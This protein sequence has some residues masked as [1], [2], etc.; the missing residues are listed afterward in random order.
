MTLF[1]GLALIA[2]FCAAWAQ[3]ESSAPDL[4]TL[5]NSTEGL[6]EIAKVVAYYPDFVEAVA[7]LTNITFLAPSDEAIIAL[8]NTTRG[9]AY[10]AEG[11]D[12]FL[13]L[14]YYHTLD[15]LYDNIT[16]YTV[17]PTLLTSSDY[18]NVTGGQV[19]GAYYEDDEELIGFY[20]GLDISP[21][22][23]R[24]PIPFSGGIMYV[25]DGVLNIPVSLT[26][27]VVGEYNGTAFVEAL[28]Q[29]GLTEEVNT[30]PDSTYFVPTNDGVE[31]VHHAL[32][33][34]SAEELADVLKYHV[35][36]GTVL[37][38]HDLEGLNG[39]TVTTLQ[40]QSLSIFM[41]PEEE[42]FINGAG[43]TYVDLYLANGVVHLIDNVLN[44]S[45]TV[46]P[47]VNGTEDGVPAFDVAASTGTVAPTTYS[48]LAAAP[49]RTAAIGGAALFAGAAVALNL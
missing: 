9:E 2:L 38:Y 1:E 25:I 17:V 4:L 32:S 33:A 30:L 23:P 42:M 34:L 18:T 12:Y 21:E 13:N 41:T 24:T 16:D 10:E 27:T 43:V 37:Y 31:A 19:V 40:G 14:L 29:T 39:S 28:D 6:S 45:A 36:P 11:D 15:G 35:V 3:T 7:G 26:K 8:A 48:G 20:S 22:G 44:P 5:L 49:M 47:P 46:T